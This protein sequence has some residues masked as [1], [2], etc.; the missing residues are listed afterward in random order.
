MYPG[1]RPYILVTTEFYT[2]FLTTLRKVLYHLVPPVALPAVF[3]MYICVC[4]SV[5]LTGL[6]ST[7]PLPPLFTWDRSTHTQ[8]LHKCTQH[9]LETCWGLSTFVYIINQSTVGSCKQ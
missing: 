7:L 2:Q 6:G 3:S 5:L 1:R 4:V 8:V 9:T